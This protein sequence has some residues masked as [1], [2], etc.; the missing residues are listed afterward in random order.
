MEVTI[1]ARKRSWGCRWRWRDRDVGGKGRG[2]IGRE[3]EVRG[4]LH[5]S[6]PHILLFP[7][8]F[9]LLRLL[10]LLCVSCVVKRTGTSHLKMGESRIIGWTI[11]YLDLGQGA[12]SSLCIYISIYLCISIHIHHYCYWQPKSR[13]M[14]ADS[15]HKAMMARTKQKLNL[16]AILLSGL[17][18]LISSSAF[19]LIWLLIEYTMLLQFISSLRNP[20]MHIYTVQYV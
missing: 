9:G 5:Y 11:Y 13:Q 20:A 4:S 7:V 19:P 15:I 14:R 12:F 2:F 10:I 16:P 17:S 8:S 18:C 6:P 3:R 1:M